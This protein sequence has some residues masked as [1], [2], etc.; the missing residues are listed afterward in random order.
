MNPATISN[1]LDKVRSIA[2]LSG[3][4]LDWTDA[5]H[6]G[7]LC[8]CD[9]G[10][11]RRQTVYMH[12]QGVSPEGQDIVV[13]LSPCIKL[14]PDG[15]G[16]WTGLNAAD[17]LRY[18]SRLNWGS[19]AV[20]FVQGQEFLIVRETQIVDTMEAEEFRINLG[21]VAKIADDIEN[22]AGVDFF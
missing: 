13:F 2:S 6:N 4:T 5:E 21:L 16:G 22:T 19:L 9:M 10:N 14:Q 12:Y 11:G 18:N 15:R 17:L 20:E 1:A 7:L 8:R 3:V